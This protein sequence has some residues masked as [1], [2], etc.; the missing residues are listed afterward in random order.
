VM[1][2]L[3]LYFQ[4][5]PERLALLEPDWLLLHNASGFPDLKGVQVAI[6]GL[7]ESR[8]AASDFCG[9]APDAIRQFLYELCPLPS[10]SGK[11]ADLGN[12]P[13]GAT[14][15]DSFVALS[16][17]V[18]MLLE[19]KIFP[20][21]LG[22]G[23]DLVLAQLA[24]YQK[25]EK[26]YHWLNID[27]KIDVFGRKPV[28][29]DNFLHQFFQNNKFLSKYTHLAHQSYL[30]QVDFLD[31]LR[32]QGSEILRLGWIREDIKEVEPYVRSA[33]AL[34][35]D[36]HA[37]RAADAPARAHFLPS[38]LFAEEACKIAHY[39]GMSETLSSAGF[40][41]LDPILDQ[42]GQSAVLFAQMVWHLLTGF[43]S[44]KG[45]FPVSDLSIYTTYHVHLSVPNRDLTFYKSPYT[46][47]W[48]M[49]LDGNAPIACSYKDYQE[50]LR[51]EIPWRFLSLFAK[52]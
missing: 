48:W 12:I 15:Q 2:D 9:Q 14:Y 3:P 34:S 43:F 38:G 36:I 8:G 21:I 26:H 52:N 40:Y 23:H 11:I 16:D 17:V 7:K 35:F 6:L 45:D 31:A 37:I 1:Q 50:A 46:G 4:P 41:N 13:A 20:I 32:A 49:T 24:A 25:L 27:A 18:R 39:A 22:G 30:N 28:L 44:R 33:D 19:K 47:R 10:F 29:S 42:Q 5:I 51:D